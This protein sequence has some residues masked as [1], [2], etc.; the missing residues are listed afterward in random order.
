MVA[1]GVRNFENL[2]KGLTEISRVIKPGAPFVVLEFSK[3]KIFP[4]KQ[5]YN[6]YFKY[7]LPGIGKFF[8]KDKSAYTYLPESV[9]AFPEGKG[10]IDALQNAGFKI[11]EELRLTFGVATIYHAVK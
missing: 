9:Q 8:S 3:P 1:F 10:F 4:V 11:I 7:I 5:F 6:F 2:H